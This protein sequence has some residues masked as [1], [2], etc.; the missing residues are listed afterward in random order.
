MPPPPQTK[1]ANDNGKPEDHLAAA[2]V[3]LHKAM[4]G[5]EVSVEVLV[6]ALA[7]EPLVSATQP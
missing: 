5:L 6:G 3:A 2:I 1:T 7:V 4:Q